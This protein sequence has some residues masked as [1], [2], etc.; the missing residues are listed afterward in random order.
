[1]LHVIGYYEDLLI[2]CFSSQSWAPKMHCFTIIFTKLHFTII[3]LVT[4]EG[5][6][7]KTKIIFYLL[8]YKKGIE[9]IVYTSHVFFYENLEM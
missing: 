8:C 4:F 9:E 3:P 6:Y 5:Y 1:M 7:K 2:Y